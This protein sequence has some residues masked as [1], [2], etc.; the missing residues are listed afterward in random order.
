MLLDMFE[1]EEVVVVQNDEGA[2]T[3]T[4]LDKS[5]LGEWLGDYSLGELWEKNE[6]GG[7]PGGNLHE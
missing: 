7:R 6:I 3:F 2:S 5:D 1:P 4:R